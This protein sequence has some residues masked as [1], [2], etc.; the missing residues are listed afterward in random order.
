MDKEG[1]SHSW[2]SG[3]RRKFQKKFKRNRQ[4]LESAASLDDILAEPEMPPLEYET[5]TATASSVDPNAL[6]A[7][8]CEE[9]KR[10]LLK[11]SWYFKIIF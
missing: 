3:L 8:D 4:K 10:E 11:L 2:F 1:S 7:Q 5:E 9:M 6:S